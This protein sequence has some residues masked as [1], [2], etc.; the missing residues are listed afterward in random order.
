MMIRTQSQKLTLPTLAAAA[1]LILPQISHAQQI[2]DQ[3][4]SGLRFR[5]IGPTAMSGRIVDLAVVEIN[6]FTFYIASST[7]GVWKTNNNGVTLTPVFYREATHSVGDVTVHQVDTNVVWVGTGERASRQSSSWGDGVYKSIDGGTT[8]TNMGL[9]DSHHIGRV[10]LHPTDPDI[11]YVAAMGHLWGPNDER[12]LYM[13][14]DGGETWNRTLFVDEN[15]GV[16]DVALDLS[17]PHILYAASYQ[18]RRRPYGFHGGGPGS[19]LFK[20]TDGGRTWRELTNGLP[21]GDKGRIGISIYRSNS[22]IVYISIEQGYRYNASTAYNERRAGVYRSEDK[23]ETWEFMSDWNPR[24]MYA[25]Q[26]LVDPNDDQRI[27]MVNTYSYSDD[28]GRTFRP[29]RQTLHGDDRLVWV[30]PADSRHVMKADD[31]G[32]GISY[33]RGITWLYLTHLPVSQ[34]YRVS[35]DMRKP[36]WVYGGLQDNGSWMGPSATYYYQG[37]RF[38]DWIKTGGGDGFVNLVD[39]TDNLTLYTESQYL[40]LSRMNLANFTSTWIRPDNARGAIGARRNWDAWGPGL[41]E[42]E[43]ANA[44]APANWDGPFIISPHDNNTLYAGTDQVWKSTDRGDTWTSLGNPTTGVNRRELRIMGQRAHDTTLSL[45]DGIPY[46]PTVSVIAESPLQPG[47]LY[48][49]TDDGNLQ[50]SI[51]DGASWTNVTDRVP[52]LP[53]SAWITGVE[54]SRHVAGTVYLAVN[55]YRN[56]DFNNYLYRSTDGGNTWSSTTGDLPPQRVVRIVR[57][58]TRN[59]NVLYVGTELGLFYSND[60]GTHWVELKNNMPTV[61]FN[62]LLVHPRDNDLVLGT[63]GRG[64]WILDNVAAL[65]E[66]NSEVVASESHLFTIEPAEMIRLSSA[67]GHTGD[68]HFAGENPPSGAIIDYYLQDRAESDAISIT[69]HNADGEEIN[70]IRPTNNSGIN[71]V[72]WNLRHTN[73]GPAM[74]AGGNN[75]GPAGPWVLPGEYTV[76]LTVSGARH[77]RTIS[78]SEDPRIEVTDAARDEWY[79]AVSRLAA[80][81][82][83]FLPLVDSVASIQERLDSLPADAKSRHVELMAE[84]DEVYPKLRELRSRLNRLY[85]QVNRAPAPFTT[86]QHSQQAYFEDWI[87]RLE[88]QV[89]RILAADMP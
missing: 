14:E 74:R 65:Q 6:P 10:V 32:L 28:G 41:P 45:D 54:P 25:S 80:T 26:P 84:I 77:E 83:S 29:A 7:G 79:R 3:T 69:I 15:T 52:G 12:G 5:E 87:G 4:L 61:A 68:M 22:N 51:D 35:V 64:I 58:D 40:G 31:G 36:Y 42:P 89:R 27:Y 9:E 21:Q 59:P 23:G 70:S 1:S 55:N 44:M 47:I 24:P 39:T 82:Q 86:D 53:E 73:I 8:W 50:V 19:G 30:N 17:N 63:H 81:V 2:T 46:Y 76:R 75:R 34:F 85:G 66:L 49:G 38:E 13:S 71:R 60:G 56:N 33:D 62:D 78:V 72:T 67:G 18:R 88:P 20:S 11:V 37:I 57:E 43:L 48:V 16:V